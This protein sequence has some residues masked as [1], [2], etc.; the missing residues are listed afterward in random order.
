MPGEVA[1]SAV[2]RLFLGALLCAAFA[3]TVRAADA[4]P[5]AVSFPSLDLRADGTQVPL[6]AL[7]WTS[8]LPGA[9]PSVVVLHGCGG[10]YSTR[11]GHENA[12][13]A[14][15]LAMAELLHRQ[16][17]NVLTVDSF[18]P[19]GTRSICTSPY[20][21]REIRPANR[22]LD[23]LAALRW[24][25]TQAEADP[26]R[27]ALLGWSNGG[28]STLDAMNQA[29]ADAAG[30]G[31]PAFRAAVAFYP[32][33]GAYLHRPYRLQSPLLVLV[34]ASDDWT[35]AAPCVA[36]QQALQPA[37]LTVRVYPDSYHDFD[38][39]ATPLRVRKDVPNGAHPGQGVT[40]GSNP[41]TR[42]AAYQDMLGFL[43][44][45]LK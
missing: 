33:C 11:P 29:H 31:L 3:T 37:P 17:Y 38:A 9:R 45:Q 15:Q 41:A 40:V 21:G 6:D 5:R 8:A 34:G 22:R 14:R 7:W 24:I 16:G 28:S 30:V 43:A 13:N 32:G 39:P 25:G 2:R 18:N 27:T 44:T 26:A 23:A 20:R 12:L 35:P 42:E 36:W 19:R 4:P 10:M 1:V